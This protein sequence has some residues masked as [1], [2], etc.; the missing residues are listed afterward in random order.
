MR[1][2]AHTKSSYA[3]AHS[4]RSASRR[5]A[6]DSRAGGIQPRRQLC[7]SP[8]AARV[9]VRQ[10]T[11]PRRLAYAA[12]RG[13]LCG[14]RPLKTG[15]LELV[16]TPV[17][18]QRLANLFGTLYRTEAIDTAAGRHDRTPA[19]DSPSA[20][21]MLG[22][23]GGT[24]AEILR[25]RQRGLTLDYIQLG[26]TRSAPAAGLRKTA[27][28]TRCRPARPHR[29]GQRQYIQYP[30]A[31]HHFS[32]IGPAGIGK[33]Y[34]AVAC[35]W[36]RWS[37]DAVKRIV[38]VRPRS[39]GRASGVPAGRRA[40]VDPTCGRSTTASRHQMLLGFTR[41]AKLFD[42]RCNRTRPLAYM[43]GAPCT[44]VRILDEAQNTTP[45][46]DEMFPHAHRRSARSV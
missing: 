46:S 40:Q 10:V 43:R 14:V 18:N 13:P 19:S 1:I 8:S 12:R 3:P 32:R 26:L 35:A 21:R 2:R 9:L 20:E 39:S 44:L 11:S 29:P 36:T 24:P 7:G 28:L 41:P 31:R 38:L 22:R 23:F 30:R 15:P 16:L 25:R 33:T 4:R 37:A 42:A 27:V 34:L 17:D 5:D 45:E 6:G